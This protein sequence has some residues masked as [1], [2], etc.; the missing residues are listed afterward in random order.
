MGEKLY[1]RIN[2]P[3]DNSRFI[4][5]VL[6]EYVYGD[7]L[8]DGLYRNKSRNTNSQ[9]I[10]FHDVL[11]KS[12]YDDW[13]RKIDSLYESVNDEDSNYNDIKSIHDF[14]N[15]Y[16][17]KNYK[18]VSNVLEEGYKKVGALFEKYCPIKIDAEGFI[19]I[20][21]QKKNRFDHGLCINCDLSK[22]HF[23]L[24]K[25][26]EKCLEYNLDFCFKFDESGFRKDSITIYSDTDNYSIYLKIL[27]DIIE[28][29]DIDS[30]LGES[31]LCIGDIS[32]KIGYVSGKVDFSKRRIRHIESCIEQET[33]KWIKK[34]YNEDVKTFTGRFVP[35]KHYLFSK[36]VIEKRHMLLDDYLTEFKTEEINSKDFTRVLTDTLI[37]NYKNICDAVYHRDYNYSLTVPYKNKTVEFTYYDFANLLKDQASFFRK[38]PGFE[39]SILWRIKNTSVGW[40][41]DPANYGM[42]IGDAYLL[43]KDINVPKRKV[44]LEM[45]DNFDDSKR[46]VRGSREGRILDS[47]IKKNK[48][49]NVFSKRKNRH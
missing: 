24:Y 29:N 38:Q 15:D 14:L 49:S 9:S 36:I 42:D 18:D 46:K 30:Y 17:V 8:F 45:L 6:Y 21:T 19:T 25:F 12:N 37:R 31:A 27:E 34:F 28:E 1:R 13:K 47:N 16:N 10:I 40:D 48:F 7:S 3:L 26:Y 23:V 4:K 11:F 5:D 2:N 20:N 35:Y 39:D 22:L 33:I 43:G 41:I 44:T 32:N